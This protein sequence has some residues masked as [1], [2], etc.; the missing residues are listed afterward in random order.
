MRDVISKGSEGVR[1]FTVKRASV[2]S[3]KQ[4]NE[5][6]SG[7][8]GPQASPAMHPRHVAKSG[9]IYAFQSPVQSRV[10]NSVYSI[11]ALITFAAALPCLAVAQT[12]DPAQAVQNG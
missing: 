3:T 11:A 1:I 6:A 9:S 10:R 8:S 5:P 4:K 7:V 2:S 12:P